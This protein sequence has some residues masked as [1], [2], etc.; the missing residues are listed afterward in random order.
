MATRA[1]R[2]VRIGRESTARR[3]CRGARPPFRRRTTGVG[4]DAH[5]PGKSREPPDP[6]VRAG[7]RRRHPKAGR[8]RGSSRRACRRETPAR[9]VGRV[10]LP[11]GR[12]DREAGHIPSAPTGRSRAG[13]CSGVRRSARS[14]LLRPKPGQRYSGATSAG[15]CTAGR[16]RLR[17]PPGKPSRQSR[18]NTAPP[19][20]SW[21]GTGPACTADAR[22]FRHAVLHP[23]PSG[24]TGLLRRGSAHQEGAGSAPDREAESGPEVPVE[25]GLL[26]PT[27]IRLVGGPAAEPRGRGFWRGAYR[28]R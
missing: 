17:G 25:D 14:L 21:D 22:G 8:R 1:S 24:H 11:G 9:A 4:G 18:A 27:G 10:V 12:P 3:T 15:R 23:L 16:S 6:K 28:F 19:A 20:E 2:N 26:E 7:P 13:G 5:V